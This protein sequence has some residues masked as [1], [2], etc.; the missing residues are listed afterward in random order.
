[1]HKKLKPF[2]GLERSTP[3]RSTTHFL[4]KKMNSMLLTRLVRIQSELNAIM[5]E[6]AGAPPTP[7][8]DAV[9]AEPEKR[10]P[11]RPRKEKKERDPNKPKKVLS[12]E[13]LAKLKEGRDLAAANKA[14]AKA[15]VSD[16]SS[17]TS[18][19]A[20]EDTEE[21]EVKEMPPAPPAPKKGRPP[22]PKT[23]VP[24]IPFPDV[25]SS[26]SE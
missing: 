1:M 2:F 17:D 16:T 23:N 25:L 3:T 18:S 15:S 26:D 19:V 20:S 10:G 12:P 5:M 24:P 9:D 6:L 11:G 8:A 21:G 4:Q 13:H 22:H 7:V 14:A